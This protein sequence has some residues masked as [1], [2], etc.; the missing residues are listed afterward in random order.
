M[1]VEAGGGK[2]PW[3]KRFLGKT[4]R[5]GI[6]HGMEESERKVRAIWH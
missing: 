5:K 3:R 4:R 2:A 6:W 1:K